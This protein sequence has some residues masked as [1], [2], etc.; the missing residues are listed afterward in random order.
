MEYFN[1]VNY[2]TVV[3]R[4]YQTNAKYDESKIDSYFISYLQ[5]FK[6]LTTYVTYIESL[7][8]GTIVGDYYKNEG[9]I[10]SPY[11]STQY[12]IGAKY[13]LFDEK[14]L[15]NSSIFR[16]EKANEYEKIQLLN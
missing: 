6:D 1:W 13:S 3:D 4:S 2:A 14:V 12:E 16:I 7:E 5:T 9:E 15:L 11:R 10:L 8:A